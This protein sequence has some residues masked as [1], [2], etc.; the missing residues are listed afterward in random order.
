MEETT[1]TDA[2]DPIYPKITHRRQ[3]DSENDS[4]KRKKHWIIIDCHLQRVH[5]PLN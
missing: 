5:M 2:N 1:I 3:S 4:E